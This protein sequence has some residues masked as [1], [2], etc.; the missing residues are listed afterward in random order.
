MQIT[1]EMLYQHASQAREIWLN[2]LPQKDEIPAIACSNRFQWK[3]NRLLRQQRRSPRTSRVLHNMKRI[4]AAFLIVA[5]ITFAGLM[6]VEAVRQKV[7]DF[8]VHVYHEF[9]EYRFSSSGEAA[10]LPEIR[11]G[12][13]PEGM[14]V[15]TDEFP[16]QF[17]RHI[18]FEDGLGHYLLFRVSTFSQHSSGTITVDTEDAE[19]TTCCLRGIEMTVIM[20]N[21]WTVILWTEEDAVF[22]VDGNLE[23]SA[24]EQVVNGLII[25]NK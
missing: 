13:L 5:T 8:V 9:T 21:G 1:D 3:M 23:L 11:F 14:E 25:S 17:A 15:V 20:K 6:T 2:T 7:I 16:T 19:I 4:A 24:L 18:Q 22:T 10:T 12:Y